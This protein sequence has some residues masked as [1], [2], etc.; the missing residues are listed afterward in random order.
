MMG[1]VAILVTRYRWLLY[2]ALAFLCFVVYQIVSSSAGV[3]LDSLPAMLIGLGIVCMHLGRVELPEDA[4]DGA[5]TWSY[6]FWLG[7]ALVRMGGSSTI[8]KH[9]LSLSRQ[10]IGMFLFNSIVG[11]PRTPLVLVGIAIFSAFLALWFR[12]YWWNYLIVVALEVFLVLFVALA[13]PVME[14]ILEA[15][16]N[17]KL[18]KVGDKV[19]QH[20]ALLERH[21]SNR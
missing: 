20:H 8:I 13:F 6:L 3:I 19:R 12:G 2:P 21:Y 10:V 7:E 11:L 15:I 5:S 14:L 16:L 4:P 9:R 17:E 1:A 18:R